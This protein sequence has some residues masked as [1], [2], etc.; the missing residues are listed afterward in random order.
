MKLQFSRASLLVGI[1][2]LVVAA[3]IFAGLY[4]THMKSIGKGSQPMFAIPGAIMVVAMFEC[5]YLI[6]TDD[7]SFLTK[8]IC[9]GV[10]GA[11]GLSC[12]L[13]AYYY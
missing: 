3:V 9:L 12:F 4:I 13:Y 5:S 8:W 1:G 11:V 7:R 2:N 10:F 6:L